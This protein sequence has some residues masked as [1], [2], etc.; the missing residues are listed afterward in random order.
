MKRSSPFYYAGIFLILT[1]LSVGTIL[2][3]R[4]IVRDLDLRLPGIAHISKQEEPLLPPPT[5][6][7]NVLTNMRAPEQ[8]NSQPKKTEKET[9]DK[10][11]KLLNDL[12]TAD[13][14]EA[15]KTQTSAPSI[16]DVEILNEKGEVIDRQPLKTPENKKAETEEDLNRKKAEDLLKQI[17]KAQGAPPGKEENKTTGYENIDTYERNTE[18]TAKKNPPSV[19]G[20]SLEA[21]SG[22]AGDI[23]AEVLTQSP[24][25]K[26]LL[27]AKKN[28]VTEPGE[29]DNPVLT[30]AERIK[31]RIARAAEGENNIMS[32]GDILAQ[33]NAS[34]APAQN[35]KASPE[36]T[37]EFDDIADIAANK[38][39]ASSDM[40]QYPENAFSEVKPKIKTRLSEYGLKGELNRA[41][42]DMFQK[43]TETASP[44]NLSMT[45]TKSDKPKR[46]D[47]INVTGGGV[48]CKFHRVID[49]AK[50]EERL[51]LEMRG[52]KLE[53]PVNLLVIRELSLER[54]INLDLDRVDGFPEKFSQMSSFCEETSVI[55]TLSEKY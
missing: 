30:E 21:L 43:S 35:K 48:I 6:E 38:K 2:G 28:S 29:T 23:E 42:K 15:D 37:L 12:D 17:N 55:T 27:E 32:E 26:A 53:D 19:Q 14:A 11:I 3:A 22:N 45:E 31:E 51:T 18:K 34:S 50:N 9:E 44:P 41:D 16:P 7:A 47:I 25:D 20:Y 4:K 46:P 36:T 8:K 5:R 52:P 33:T 1:L 54:Y 40:A 10:R 49:T 13:L 39:D 24:V